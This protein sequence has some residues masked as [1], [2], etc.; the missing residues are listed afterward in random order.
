MSVYEVLLGVMLS[1][2]GSSPVGRCCCWRPSFKPR[3]E[4]N[5][6]N[7]SE[8]IHLAFEKSKRK[9]VRKKKLFS[10]QTCVES[11]VNCQSVVSVGFYQ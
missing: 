3:N 9:V 1:K 2:W 7:Y 5:F 8:K 10:S 11:S 6:D 4:N